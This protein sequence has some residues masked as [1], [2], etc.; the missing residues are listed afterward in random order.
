MDGVKKAYILNHTHWDREWYE[1]FEAFRYKLRNGLRYIQRLLEKGQMECFFLDGQTVVLED[2][3]E[4][5]SEKEFSAFT[6]FIQKGQVEV[7]PWYLLAD[8]FLVSGESILKNLEVGIK[9]ARALGSES[10]IGY[11]PDTFGHNSQMPQLFKGYGIDWALLWRGAVSDHF[12]V[13]W[14]GADGSEVFAFVLPLMEGYYQTYLKSN[15]YIEKTN[16]YLKQNQ[17]YLTFDQ[18][19]I[20]NGADHTFPAPDMKHRVQQLNEHVEDTVFQ[21]ARMADFTAAFQQK[22]PEAGLEGEQRDPSKIFILPGVYSTRTYLKHQNQLCEDQALYIMEALNV[23]SKGESR[24]EAFIEYIWK[25]ILKNHPHDSI[26]GCSVDEV[27]EEMET[28]TQKILSAIDQFSRDVLH[29][30]YPFEFLNSEVENNFLYL[31]NN[32]PF[33]ATYPVEATIFIPIAQDLG[34]IELYH[35]DEKIKMDIVK[36]EQREEF[37]RHIFAEPHYGEYAVYD[38]SMLVPFQGVETKAFQIVRVKN[39][40]PSAGKAGDSFIENEFYRIEW[41]K[42]GLTISDKED[43]QVYERQHQFI[44]SLDAGDTYNYS[45]PIHDCISEGTLVK[46]TDLTKGTTFQ[47]AVLHY[48]LTCP[49][50]LNQER[51]G[52]SGETVKTIIKTKVTLYSDVRFIYFKSTVQNKAKDQKLRIGF[53]VEAG[54]ISYGDTPFDLVERRRLQEKIYDAP[55][56][57]EAIMNQYPAYST[58]ITGEHQLAHRGLQEYEVDEYKGNTTA[59]LTVIRSVGWLSRRDLRTR[60]NGAGPGFE[61]PGAQCIGSYEFEY[62][63]ILGRKHHSINH[64]KLLRHKVLSQQSHVQKRG[65]LL[66][67]QTDPDIAFSSF[68]KKES[69]SIDIRMFNPNTDTRTTALCFGFEPF[70]IEEVDFKGNVLGELDAKKRISL[71]FSSKQIKTIRVR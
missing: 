7:G 8:E 51:T 56:N 34:A 50:S 54:D 59:F 36:R 16:A 69:D 45:P 57:K 39:V 63:L 38:I 64:A 35:Q 23:W 44:S 40:V 22:I 55:P 60:G 70:K 9:Q 52:A 15:E 31:I 66:F 25:M 33:E 41:G 30:E 67:Y 27:H 42:D 21:Q 11:L 10:N 53:A 26:C 46:V 6:S 3:K 47:S 12:E 62:G 28:R 19:L 32:T 17:P 43:G 18:A 2:F 14:K 58:V 65:S 5:V 48:E 4:I 49:A 1:P 29:D 13:N 71:S 61:T 68:I 37:M 20:L 24:S